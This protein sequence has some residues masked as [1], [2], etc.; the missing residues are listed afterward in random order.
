MNTTDIFTSNSTN[1]SDY[2]VFSDDYNITNQGQEE[3]DDYE[4]LGLVIWYSIWNTFV[5]LHV[6]PSLFGMFRCRIK[7]AL[8]FCLPHFW[9][10][11][12]GPVLETYFAGPRDISLSLL[13]CAKAVIPPYCI[14]G[15][16]MTCCIVFNSDEDEDDSDSDSESSDVNGDNYEVGEVELG[17]PHEEVTTRTGHTIDL[18][19]AVGA[20]SGGE[21]QQGEES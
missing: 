4:P 8:A 13:V 5:A 7:R 6:V 1:Q 15:V 12:L 16:L 19:K 21:E 20:S 10:G 17:E 9:I 2:G 18:E 11:I 14:V 3:A